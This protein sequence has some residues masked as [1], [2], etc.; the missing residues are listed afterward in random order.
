MLQKEKK[1]SE[2][3]LKRQRRTRSNIHGTAER[4]RLCAHRSLRYISAQLIDDDKQQTV[5]ALSEEK[6]NL[7][8]N[9]VVKAQEFGKQL[10]GKLAEKKITSVVFDRGFYQYHGRIKALAEVL[11]EQG[12]KF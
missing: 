4:P 1:N 9:K 7:T 12:I 10:A 3:R 6:L 11:R 2:R 8:G 5:L